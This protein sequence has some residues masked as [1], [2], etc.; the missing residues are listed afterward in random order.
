MFHS[1]FF[2][3]ITILTTFEFVSSS[4]SCSIFPSFNCSC[5]QSNS[6]LSRKI[7]SHL[8]CQGKSLNAK[9]F[10]P[11][12]GSD[13]KSQNHFHTLSIDFFLEN[14]VEIHSNQFDSLSILFSK[15]NPNVQIHVFVRFHGFTRIQID[16]YSFNEKTFEQ[17]PENKHLWLYFLPMRINRSQVN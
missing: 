7:Y 9:T 16:E 12:F 1:N 4:T 15:T 3:L 6:N 17:R 14:D 10:Q 2:I 11:P 13:F 5:F 8:Y